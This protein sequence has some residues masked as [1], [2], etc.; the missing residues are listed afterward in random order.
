MYFQSICF[1]IFF[2]KIRKYVTVPRAIRRFSSIR[3]AVRQRLENRKFFAAVYRKN[4]VK[5]AI[6][7]KNLLQSQFR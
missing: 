6:C 5:Y 3:D 2:Q 7:P 4:G 1:R